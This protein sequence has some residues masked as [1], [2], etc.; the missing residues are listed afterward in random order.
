MMMLMKPVVVMVLLS[1]VTLGCD[2]KADGPARL[3]ARYATPDV[4]GADVVIPEVDLGDVAGEGL[5]GRWAMRMTLEGTISPL[6]APWDITLTN[7]FIVDVDVD[8]DVD[9]GSLPVAALTFCDQISV[10]D[11][12][13]GASDLGRSEVPV[14]LRDALASQPLELPLD[15]S[16]IAAGELAWTWGLRDLDDPKSSA[17]PEAAEDPRVWDQDADGH[18]GVTMEII[19]PAGQRYMV[20]R[21]L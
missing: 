14:P 5:T 13:K 4:G 20:R 6:S 15:A 3:E 7:L 18:P 8:G 9:D 1:L 17:L 11:T 10:I 21:A 19:N 12:G 2:W 16:G